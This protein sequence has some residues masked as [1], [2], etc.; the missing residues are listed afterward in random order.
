MAKE[1]TEK[2][3]ANKSWLWKKG[4]SGN[5]AGRPK[6]KTLK[7]RA[8]E[9]FLTMTEEEFTAFL[10]GMPKLDVWQMAEGRPEAK[11]EAKIETSAPNPKILEYA[12]MLVNLQKNGNRGTDK[13]SGTDS[14]SVSES[15][16]GNP[17]E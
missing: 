4:Q 1:E 2:Q 12:E 8:R 7:E 17:K 10:E 9:L 5:P 3:S 14:A 13:I 16:G 11:I 15:V 6:G